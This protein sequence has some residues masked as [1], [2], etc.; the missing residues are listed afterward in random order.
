LVG[1]KLF[2]AIGIEIYS[3]AYIYNLIFVSIFV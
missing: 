3:K 2:R 1:S